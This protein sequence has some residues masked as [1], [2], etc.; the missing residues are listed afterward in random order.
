V[1]FDSRTVA[2]IKFQKALEPPTL[3]G[4]STEEIALLKRMMA[5]D[6]AD[7]PQTYDELIAA[8][9]ALPCMEMRTEIPGRGRFK[10]D[11]PFA[12]LPPGEEL[13]PVPIAV[14]RAA[15]EPPI[16]R[17]RAL[18]RLFL[19]AIGLALGAGFAWLFGAFK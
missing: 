10:M 15:P 14:P 13:V 16:M 2:E 1:P 7:R 9:D 6:P 5:R 3:P 17:T 11:A 4:G 18:Q 12:P 8:I 19:L